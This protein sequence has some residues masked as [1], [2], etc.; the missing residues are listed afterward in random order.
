MYERFTD[1]ARKVM[2]IAN[3]TA[4]EY[5]GT[6]HIARALI[7]DRMGSVCGLLRRVGVDPNEIDQ[8]LTDLCKPGPEPTSLEKRHRTPRAKRALELAEVA[9]RDF[10]NEQVNEMHLLFGVIRE[11]E[12]DSTEGGIGGQILYEAGATTEKIQGLMRGVRFD[13]VPANLVPMLDELA[14]GF[15]IS[16]GQYELLLVEILQTHIELQRLTE[17]LGMQ[18]E[19]YPAV[20]ARAINRIGTRY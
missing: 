9:S 1:G 5:I 12:S 19:P 11:Y 18:G 3:D 6:E 7:Q 4:N 17:F 10:E 15:G 14:K 16:E 8:R 13:R 20:I 2:Q